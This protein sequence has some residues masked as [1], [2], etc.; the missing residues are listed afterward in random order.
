[1]ATIVHFDISA[2]DTGRA[3]AFY[4]QLFGWKI[5]KIGPMDYYMIS[6]N[7]LEGKPGL[8]GGMAKREAGS[9]MGVTNFIGVASIDTTLEQITQLGGKV[10][11]QPQPVPGYGIMALC[12]DTEDNV[13]GIFEEAK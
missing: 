5:E 6:T 13:F 10:M 11:S 1:M 4:E 12:R 3:K 9:H 2:D 7:D 8:G